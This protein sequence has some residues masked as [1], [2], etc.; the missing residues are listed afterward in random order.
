LIPIL[1]AIAERCI[2]RVVKIESCFR[3]RMGSAQKYEHRE[4]N[5]C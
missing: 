5:S 2:K 4:A 3:L 1:T